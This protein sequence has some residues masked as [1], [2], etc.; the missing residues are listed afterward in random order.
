[1][2]LRRFPGPAAL[3]FVFVVSCRTAPRPPPPA[4]PTPLPTA[5][6]DLVRATP[7]DVVDDLPR[8]SLV[9]A[10]DR[11]LEAGERIAAPSC[12]ASE[13]SRAL[14]ALRDAA[15]RPDADLAAFVR[16]QFVFGRSTGRSGGALFTGYYEPVLT[17]RRRRDGTFVYPIYRRPDDL[18]EI[19]LGDFDAAFAAITIYGRVAGGKLAPYYTRR[20]IDGD[21][22]LAGRGLEIAWLD[23]PVARYF[24][25]IQG[26][27]IIQL[28]D[29]AAQRVGFASSNGKP[30]TSIG[31]LLADD[32]SLGAEKPT[33]PAIQAFLRAHP[34]RQDDV[35][36]QN[37]RYV[38]FR[39]VVDG[40]LGHLGVKLTDGRSIAVD[41][42]LYPL[43]SLGYIT[44]EASSGHT[45]LRRLVL[46]Q[47]TG[48]AITGPGRVDVFFGTGD[49][50]GE[51]AGVMSARGELYFLVPR[52]C[53]SRAASESPSLSK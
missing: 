18:I 46:V 3:V 22:V 7:P 28:E 9:V 2:R 49:Q 38:F 24:L 11:D 53:A 10:I 47:D 25:H 45:P 42:S 40:P 20:E 35:L 4:L 6:P 52:A 8:D 23:D 16:E 48:G 13:T 31:R 33:A 32:G 34:E 21:R 15:A 17:G 51:E 29:G 12:S 19:R 44:T 27:G 30:Y 37:E 50:A 41:A 5:T 1:V 39:E 14:V 26:S 43:G 36:F